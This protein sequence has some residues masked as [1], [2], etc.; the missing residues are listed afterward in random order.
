MRS[1]IFSQ[2]R[3]EAWEFIYNN[4][5]VVPGYPYNQY[6]TIKKIYKYVNSKFVS[7]DVDSAGNRKLFYNIVLPRCQIAAKEIDLSTKDINVISEN[8]A[9][10]Y[11]AWFFKK[12]LHQ[13]MKEK[14]FASALNRFGDFL[15]QFG[16]VVSKM[17]KN[18]SAMNVDLRNLFVD[19]QAPTMRA[20]RYVIEKHYY[21]PEE[22]TTIADNLGWEHVDEV[23]DAF[24]D[25][26]VRGSFEDTTV[27]NSIST[28]VIPVYER[29]GEV[30]ESWVYDDGDPEKYVF[31]CF[32]I[33]SFSGVM[34]NGTPIERVLFK[35]E[36][37]KETEFPYEECHWF[38]VP[39]RWL[40]VGEVEML[41]VPQEA[42]NQVQNLFYKGLTWS[43][44]HLYQSRDTLIKANILQD[45]EN[46]DII[47]SHSEIT[48]LVNEER[49]LSA[50]SLALNQWVSV[51]D[52]L[53]FASDV[54]KGATLPSRTSQGTA[55]LQA[56][57]SGSY[58]AKKRE[59]FGIFIKNVIC[60]LVI[61]QFKKDISTEHLFNL[62]GAKDTEI[63]KINKLIFNHTFNKRL[64]E[65]IIESGIPSF[66]EVQMLKEATKVLQAQSK[67]KFVK[68][69][70]DFYD[71]LKYHIDV[72]ITGESVNTQAKSQAINNGMQIINNNPNVL[73]NPQLKRMFMMLFDLAGINPIDI[74]VTD[75]DEDSMQNI[76]QLK[77]GGS[78][79][80]GSPTI[81]QVAP[82]TQTI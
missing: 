68:I 15:P 32:V 2:L 45:L 39:G 72:D 34:Q 81:P 78:L 7:G 73:K 11:P 55:M 5:E 21:S 44:L 67:E 41:F 76:A 50:Y 46:G 3:D 65:K 61:P 70:K 35:S 9:S 37:D 12:E 48:P 29:W 42:V 56:Q 16:T 40:G 57:M 27:F 63:D 58:F 60:R 77:Q 8:G 23:I 82:E 79:S 51:A 19:P 69:P 62:V 49:N 17:S 54:A 52:E 6:E 24:R 4:I 28:P 66:E 22:L 18:A 43:A 25:I 80:L 71:D 10:Y 38:K 14:G 59:D 1:N 75:E 74:D 20:A 53:T 13:W 47:P 64:L 36:M 33:T 26:S 30:P 31:A